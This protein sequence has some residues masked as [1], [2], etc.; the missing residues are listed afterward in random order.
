[1]IQKKLFLTIPISVI[2]SHKIQFDK[3]VPGSKF[4][5]KVTGTMYWQ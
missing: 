3:S 5:K 1:M 2:A 4:A